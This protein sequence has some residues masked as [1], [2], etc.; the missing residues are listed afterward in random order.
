MLIDVVTIFPQLFSQLFDFG[1][2]RQA[3]KRKVLQTRV[4]DLREFS[5]D[6]RRTVDDRPYGGGN[7]MVFKPE[8]V[9]KAV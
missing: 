4:I 8:P 2:I 9:F 1:I 5:T 3:R 7:G 6:K